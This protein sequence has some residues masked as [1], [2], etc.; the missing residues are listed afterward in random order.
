[1]PSPI[2]RMTLSG[3]SSA[4]RSAT[5]SVQVA[6]HSISSTSDPMA[7]MRKVISVKIISQ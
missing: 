2:N 4:R 1:M 5:G 7:F 6:K 3:R